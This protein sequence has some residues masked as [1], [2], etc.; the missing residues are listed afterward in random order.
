MARRLVKVRFDL[1]SSDWHGIGSETL[2]AAAENAETGSFRLM[3]SPFFARGIGYLD[4]VRTKVGAEESNTFDYQEVI[5]RSGHS[6]YMILTESE[7][8]EFQ[9][10]W[11]LLESSGCSYESTTIQLSIGR[12]I[13]L[14]V[15]VPPAA[16]LHEVYDLLMKGEDDGI[17]I[18]QEG[19]ACPDAV[20]RR[21]TG[22]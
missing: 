6:T 14:S 11:S 1:D 15:D 18:F 17:W 22:P 21:P 20:A 10:L 2:W 9:K 4:V 12:R 13:L 3:N 7:S 16:N 8:M 19:F 5:E